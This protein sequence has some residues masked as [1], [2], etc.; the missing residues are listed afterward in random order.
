M[1]TNSS[2]DDSK[3][4]IINII[5]LIYAYYSRVKLSYEARAAQNFRL[6]SLKKFRTFKRPDA[7]VFAFDNDVNSFI[8]RSRRK[9]F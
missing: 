9:I 8:A 4:I 6:L 2:I 7:S 3:E 1:I 5:L